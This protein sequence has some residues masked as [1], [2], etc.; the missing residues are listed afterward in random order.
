MAR[1]NVCRGMMWGDIYSYKE[2]SKRVES[3]QEVLVRL[4]HTHIVLLQKKCTLFI[5]MQFKNNFY[6]LLL[7]K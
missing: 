3:S 1:K 4:T 6:F 2:N 5:I 7:F